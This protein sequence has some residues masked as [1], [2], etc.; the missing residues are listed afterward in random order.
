MTFKPCESQTHLGNTVSLTSGQVSLK[1]KQKNH[2]IVNC[3]FL[4]C[5]LANVL[6]LVHKMCK[7]KITKV[8]PQILSE[9]SSVDGMTP[10][11]DCI[12]GA[13]QPSSIYEGSLLQPP[14]FL[15]WGE[16]KAALLKSSWIIFMC[17][18]V[19]QS[20]WEGQFVP[21]LADLI[22]FLNHSHVLNTKAPWVQQVEPQ[23][24]FQF[25]EKSVQYSQGQSRSKH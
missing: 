5:I 4:L 19:Y 13:D 7:I 23:T 17:V 18:F 22:C 15:V 12:R 11:W 14:S 1:G 9:P 8:F 20:C 24:L 6:S 3:F 16:L 10:V 25:H 21:N 2:K